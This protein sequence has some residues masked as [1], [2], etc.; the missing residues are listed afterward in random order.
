MLQLTSLTT[1]YYSI[2]C[3]LGIKYRKGQTSL[4][5]DAIAACSNSDWCASS[6]DSPTVAADSV[7]SI[8]C[9]RVKLSSVAAADIAIDAVARVESCR[10]GCEGSED[11]S[12]GGAIW[13][14]PHGTGEGGGCVAPSSLTIDCVAIC[15]CCN[16]GTQS[17][18]LPIAVHT[19]LHCTKYF[20]QLNSLA[21][22]VQE[23]YTRHQVQGDQTH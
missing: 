13:V 9:W 2:A 19:V 14:P 17:R 7:R 23:A 11:G 18:F 22:P 8:C 1:L 3:M 12:A 21:H 15:C 16:K 10:T 6:S 20:P 5:M 4:P